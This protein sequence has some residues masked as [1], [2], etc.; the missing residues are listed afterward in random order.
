MAETKQNRHFNSIK[1][2][3]LLSISTRPELGPTD[4]LYEYQQYLEGYFT[5]T[6]SVRKEKPKY[7]VCDERSKLLLE[8]TVGTE[9]QNPKYSIEDILLPSEVNNYRRDVTNFIFLASDIE[10]YKQIAEAMK[11]IRSNNQSELNDDSLIENFTILRPFG[12]EMWDIEMINFC[13][14]TRCK[15]ERLPIILPLIQEDVL[16]MQID[17]AFVRIYSNFDL[18]ILQLCAEGINDLQKVI[19]RFPRIH[20]LGKLSRKLNIMISNPIGETGVSTRFSDCFIFDR[21]DD[22]ITPHMQGYNY[23]SMLDRVEDI[24][25]DMTTVTVDSSLLI[26]ATKYNRLEEVLKGKM[27]TIFPLH[28]NNFSRLRDLQFNTFPDEIKQMTSEFSEETLSTTD[29]RESKTRTKMLLE[30][31]PKQFAAFMFFDCHNRFYQEILA[32][33]RSIDFRRERDEQLEYILKSFDSSTFSYFSDYDPFSKIEDM[34]Y[35]SPTMET[36]LQTSR[37]FC[38]YAFPD[39]LARV[40][41]RICFLCGLFGGIKSNQLDNIKKLLIQFYGVW[42]A[43][44]FAKMEACGLIYRSDS[45]IKRRSFADIHRCVNSMSKESDFIGEKESLKALDGIYDHYQPLIVNYIND[46]FMRITGE[47][48]TTVKETKRGFFDDDEDETPSLKETIDTST[49]RFDSLFAPEEKTLT[50]NVGEVNPRS[51]HIF[52]FVIG[53]ISLGE[54]SMLKLIGE[55]YNKKVI[56]ASTNVFRRTQSIP[57]QFIESCKEEYELISTKAN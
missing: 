36:F 32:L 44:V 41:S 24:N 5:K 48:T 26:K 25:G 8:L 47:Y 13:D 22:L 56:I 57:H 15:I 37:V 21:T 19:G 55:R 2:G 14:M 49:C 11:K 40:L 42:V 6:L 50:K 45:Q 3:E 35:D 39:N 27:E 7:I 33:A 23:Y 9:L 54:I 31:L 30:M 52:V 34:I 53:G 1:I 29:A 12:T 38:K 4:I 43:S 10:G 16:S 51:D 46:Y 28:G 20:S 18:G 17:D